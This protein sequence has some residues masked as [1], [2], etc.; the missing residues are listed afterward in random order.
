MNVY[1]SLHIC[2]YILFIRENMINMFLTVKGN[3]SPIAILKPLIF[4]DFFLAAKS[5]TQRKDFRCLL[6]VCV[7]VCDSACANVCMSV[8]LSVRVFWLGCVCMFVYVSV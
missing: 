4:L 5:V 1:I 2:V 8:C 6:E 3:I 7:R